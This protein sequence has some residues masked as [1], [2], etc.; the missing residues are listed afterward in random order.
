MQAVDSAE[1]SLDEF[2]LR[3]GFSLAGGDFSRPKRDITS[4][5]KTVFWTYG[6]CRLTNTPRPYGLQRRLEPEH[7]W[8]DG[9]GNRR[10][11]NRWPDFAKGLNEPKGFLKKIE[12]ACPGSSGCLESPLWE[13]LAREDLSI[14]QLQG[15][16]TKLSAPIQA[17]IKK[18]GLWPD[19]HVRKEPK[20]I[21]G[22][23]AA[24]LERRACLDALAAVVLLLR[25][26][27]AS[28][29]PEIS[30]RWGRQLWRM[31]ALLTPVLINGGISRALAELI[32]ERIMP[33][34]R[35]A[36]AR[37]GFPPGSLVDVAREFTKAWQL[38]TSLGPTG[39]LRGVARRAAVGPDLLTGQHGWDY[40][41]AFHP[42]TLLDDVRAPQQSSDQ[43]APDVHHATQSLWLHTWGHNMLKRGRHPAS[44]PQSVWEGVDLQIKSPAPMELWGV[45]SST[46]WRAVLL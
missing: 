9:D 8:R 15:L 21:D 23:F 36:G 32:Q 42:V 38:Y 22:K 10:R 40:H 35:L 7:L 46:Y 25:V 11:R 29:R 31:W 13:G 12:D 16:M 18:H 30:Y 5:L 37:Y 19:E 41:F 20:L 6:L 45:K 26:A 34:A 17:L 33:M 44:P 27:H 43:P 3:A 24:A 14:Q 2:K 1:L 39:V 4:A 28:N